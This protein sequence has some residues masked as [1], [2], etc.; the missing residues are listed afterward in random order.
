[1]GACRLDAHEAW[2]LANA[3]RFVA[4]AFRGTRQV[5]AQECADL[6][7]APAPQ[8]SAEDAAVVKSGRHRSANSCAATRVAVR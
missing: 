4:C 6:E 7:R 5:R 1:M 3:T 8:R 2:V